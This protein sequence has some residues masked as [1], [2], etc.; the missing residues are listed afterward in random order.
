M[1]HVE[2]TERE[3]EK[4]SHNAKI[5]VLAVIEPPPL[6][7]I[8]SLD[9]QIIYIKREVK[10]P[11]TERCRGLRAR[12]MR[13][14]AWWT[15]MRIDILISVRRDNNRHTPSTRAPISLRTYN[16]PPS[17]FRCSM[18]CVCFVLF[19]CLSNHFASTG[20]GAAKH[21]DRF[22]KFSRAQFRLKESNQ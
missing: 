12:A 17:T 20:Q 13:Y 11:L 16:T 19:V 10:V 5:E 18:F 15:I 8:T 1:L 2:K 21:R 22:L 6:R 3:R 7:Y 14:L 9:I 4:T